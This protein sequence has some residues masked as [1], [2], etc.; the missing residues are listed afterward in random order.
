MGMVN[1]D[2]M[3]YLVHTDPE[4]KEIIERIKGIETKVRTGIEL[5]IDSMNLTEG[6]KQNMKKTL[7]EVEVYYYGVNKNFDRYFEDINREELLKKH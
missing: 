1:T 7:N 3:T 5:Y 4:S 2:I 6:T